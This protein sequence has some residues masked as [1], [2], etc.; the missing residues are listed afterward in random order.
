MDIVDD[1]ITLTMVA[2]GPEKQISFTFE[3]DHKEDIANLIAS[4][5]PAHSNWQ[6]VG[7]A[8]TRVVCQEGRREGRGGEGRG[9]EGRGGE[10]RGG[11][12]RGGEGRGGEGRGGEG[13]GGEG[14]GGEGRG[15]E[16]RGEWVMI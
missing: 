13:R 1:V 11:E 12:G 6:R 14:R 4:Y 5:S 3:T 8:K 10:G 7:E 9:G 2:S 16:G 15:G